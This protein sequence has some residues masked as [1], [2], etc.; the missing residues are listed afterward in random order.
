VRAK[1]TERSNLKDTPNM[2][3]TPSSHQMRCKLLFYIM[4]SPHIAPHSLHIILLILGYSYSTQNKNNTT[5]YFPSKKPSSSSSSYPT[6]KV[7]TQIVLPVAAI[8]AAAA[9]IPITSAQTPQEIQTNKSTSEMGY[10]VEVFEC[11]R[12]LNEL[13][14]EDRH[15]KNMGAVV[16]ICFRPNQKAMDDKVHIQSVGSWH[17]EM[18]HKNGWAEY[19]AVKDGKGDSVLS[20]MECVDQG[21][22]CYLDTLLTAEFYE[23][24]GSVMGQGWASLTAFPEE[25]LKLEKWMFQ[26]DFSFKFVNGDGEEMSEGEQAELMAAMEKQEEEKANK[27]QNVIE[28]TASGHDTHMMGSAAAPGSEL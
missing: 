11:D 26:A 21:A 6:M 1:V 20:Q 28:A 24:K 18:E 5:A 23:H 25:K 12:N 7:L 8:A 3:M 9:S 22:I 4:P 19:E 2:T 27:Q 17:W 13:S 16:R 14:L 15:K 10:N